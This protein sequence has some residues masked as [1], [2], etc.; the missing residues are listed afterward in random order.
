[1]ADYKSNDLL[2]IESLLDQIGARIERYRIA[3][4]IKQEDLAER[5]G[6]SSRTLRRL[7]A[8]GNGTLDTVARVLRA[9]DIEDRL[10]ALV[11][12]ATLSP[13]DPRSDGKQPRQRVRDSAPVPDRPWQWGDEDAT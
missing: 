13:L 10:L 2:P 5:A 9:L 8:G 4:R 11:P 3:R 6:I 12:D 1:M 7:E